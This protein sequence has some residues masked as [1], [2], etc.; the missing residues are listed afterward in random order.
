MKTNTPSLKLFASATLLALAFG[1]AACSQDSAPNPDTP[2]VLDGLEV[3]APSRNELI[4][5][6][7]QGNASS[8]QN[9]TL[10]NVGSESLELR[11]LSLSGSDADAFT[12]AEPLELPAIL[13][14]NES[15]STAVTFA[16]E[17]VGTQTASLEVRS[18]D[19]QNPITQ[20]GLYG[21]GTQGEQG[22]NEPPLQDVVDT[23]GYMVNVGS[24]DLELGSLPT[25]IGDETPVSMFE[26][27]G[28]GPVRLEVVARYSPE[29]ILPFGYF[30]VAGGTPSHREVGQIG[31][32]NAQELLPPLENGVLEFEPESTTFGIY[33]EAGGRTQ[34]S[35]DTL[36]T[37]EIP[38]AMRVYPNRDRSGNSIP[39]SY[40]IG[41]EEAENAD[42]QDT[43]MVLSNVKPSSLAPEQV[44]G[45]RP[46]FNGQ[47]L[48]GWYSYLP[49]K[50]KNNDPEGVFRVE[51]GMLHILG[52]PNNGHRE[53]GYVAT[54]ASYENYKLRFQYK[55][56]SQKFAPRQFRKRDSGVIYHFTG[57]D[58]VWPTGVEYQIQE[59]DTGDFWLIGGTKLQTTVETPHASAP[60]YEQY[61]TT[62][63]SRPGRF[64][65]IMKDG[66]YD[67]YND[68]NTV[69]ITVQGNTATHT[70]NG[71]VNNRAYK[72][73]GPGGSPLTQGKILLQ[74]EGAEIFYRNIEIQELGQ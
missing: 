48:D 36:N 6:S 21:L 14:P 27:A 30:T 39:N 20:V 65:R 53:F 66:T 63:T 71:K 28:P 11:S 9:V 12:L 18:S 64:V 68:W 33:A 74:A 52:V 24:S 7:I 25:P 43:V 17:A 38:H 13:E 10:T 56:G 3:A 60:R 22:S 2:P 49:S 55:W 51:N 32:E 31:A 1:L 8:A 23:L 44:D 5:S 72:L 15:L 26:K 37:G 42:Y 46:L 67:H 58:K 54:E 19:P 50:G 47:N 59:G 61:G 29:E 16:P 73:F 45:W 70:I 4:F 35:D 57:G 69:E 41:V 62:Y 40:L 34:Y